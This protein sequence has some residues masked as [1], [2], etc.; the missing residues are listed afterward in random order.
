MTLA[1]RLQSVT[2]VLLD[3]A[4]V[5]YYVEKHPR[6][7]D[8]V[9]AVFDGLDLGVLSAVTSPVTLAECLVF[10]YRLGQVGLVREF[11]DLIIHGSSTDFIAIDQ[12]TA[13]AAANLRARYNVSLPDAFQ[14]AI[15]LAADCDA[16][17]TN[18]AALKRV[19]ELDVIVLDDL[20]T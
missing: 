4:P 12:E 16:L 11:T 18:D 17:L 7:V 19:T 9:Q 10:P 5:I 3:S 13:A 15:A 6:Y 20:T 2:R 14:I 1:E 8:I